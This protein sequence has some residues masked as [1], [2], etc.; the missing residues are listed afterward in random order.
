MYGHFTRDY[1]YNRR[2]MPQAVYNSW[3]DTTGRVNPNQDSTDL[4][5]LT[6][7]KYDPLTTVSDSFVNSDNASFID[8][9]LPDELGGDDLG[10]ISINDHSDSFDVIEAQSSN[11]NA[12]DKCEIFG[13]K[14]KGLHMCNLN[15]R[16]ILPMIDE[17][18]LT[19]SKGNIPDV[20]GL[21]ESF[22]RNAP[23]RWS[24]LN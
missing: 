12:A 2:S 14:S 18:R 22:F 19:L 11:N 24:H 10:D 15:V 6:Y 8:Q 9:V 3:Q 16:H 7:N 13:F 21:C 4:L 17:I 1:W 23:P 20:L 5:I